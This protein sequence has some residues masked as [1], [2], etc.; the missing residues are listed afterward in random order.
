M[1][2][3]YA[4]PGFVFVAAAVG[5]GLYWA[6]VYMHTH[7]SGRVLPT[8]R[9]ALDA[10]EPKGGWPRVCVLAPAHNE[11]EVIA[12][13]ATSLLASDYPADRLSFVFALDRCTDATR[14]R[15]DEAIVDARS[16]EEPGRAPETQGEAR[17]PELIEIDECPD[18]WAGKVHALH[19]A[20]NRSEAA[21][22]AEV[23]LFADADTMFHPACLRAA[24]A[25]LRERGLGLLSL[26]TTLTVE[27]I[28][29]RRVQPAACFELVRQ[30][31]PLKANGVGRRRAF[32]NGQFMMFTKAAY[33]AI[34]GHEA[35]KDELLEDVAFARLLG[36]RDDIA[37][38]C[39]E[40][41][42]V[43]RCE[44]YRDEAAFER[45]WKRI[46]Q[47]A[48]HRKPS[49]VRRAA[50]TVTLTGV[51]L[52]AAAALAALWGLLGNASGLGGGLGPLLTFAGAL[53]LVQFFGTVGVIYRRQH[54]P[55]RHVWSFPYGCW[56]TAAM[57]RDAAWKLENG[58]RTAWG[59]RTYVRKARA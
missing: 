7:A 33:D 23:L 42:G 2:L 16:P 57:L 51:A 41:D 18:D 38:G 34:G 24:V 49:R 47:E 4:I 22:Q 55:L 36:R 54:V 29:E 1:P 52:P 44:M 46:Y 43:L 27:R 14:A 40:A 30:F 32:A 50:R 37:T 11:E 20:V 26:Y 53:A 48:A 21:R 9:D 10:P 31:P 58:E 45:G 12:R 35:V 19:T 17:E 13:L 25:T 56:R 3:W 5:C 6:I 59:G 8:L 39:L 28:W 15:L